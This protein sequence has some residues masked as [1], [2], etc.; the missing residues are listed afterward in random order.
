MDKTKCS[1][2]DENGRIQSPALRPCA[3]GISAVKAIAIAQAEGQETY[4]IN[5]A[6]AQTALAKLPIGGEVG[7]EIRIVGGLPFILALLVAASAIASVIALY[8]MEDGFQAAACCNTGLTDGGAS[9]TTYIDYFP[10]EW[11]T[12]E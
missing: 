6:N 12:M 4:T 9:M 5:K 7:S 10:Q 3:K 11:E 8:T 2:T 1:Y